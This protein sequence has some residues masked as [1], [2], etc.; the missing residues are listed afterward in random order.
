MQN[1]NSKD[2]LLNLMIEK[3]IIY[4]SFI[5]KKVIL[6]DFLK[7]FSCNLLSRTLLQI[8]CIELLEDKSHPFKILENFIFLIE[9]SLEKND[10]F[11]NFSSEIID[12]LTKV[13]DNYYLLSS[14]QFQ[15]YLLQLI[16]S[17]LNYISKQSSEIKEVN[18]YRQILLRIKPLLLSKNK[19]I[20]VFSNEIFMKI[21][22]L[23]NNKPM[24]IEDNKTNFSTEDPINVTINDSLAV[25]A[26]EFFDIFIYILEKQD[27]LIAFLKTIETMTKIAYFKPEFFNSC[28]RIEKIWENIKLFIDKTIKNPLKKRIITQISNFISLIK[29]SSISIQ[30]EIPN[31]LIIPK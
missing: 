23:I 7:I 25:I 5:L 8:K 1:L 27:N 12:N 21:L 10:F 29:I 28:G 30:I 16:I 3:H 31:Y 14:N 22:P 17:I 15:I 6:S 13:Y 26:A 19:E 11:I 24:N 20:I 9:K 2:Y 18:F 4:L